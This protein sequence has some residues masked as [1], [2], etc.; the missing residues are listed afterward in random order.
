MNLT[1]WSQINYI[2]GPTDFVTMPMSPWV[3]Y[4]SRLCSLVYFHTFKQSF[5]CFPFY[6]IFLITQWTCELITNIGCVRRYHYLSSLL[7]PYTCL[8][9]HR[10]LSWI[11]KQFS[12]YLKGLASN[13]AMLKNNLNGYT[14]SS[15][16]SHFS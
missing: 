8:F 3:K 2:T 4:P 6:F 16:L 9:L 13:I 15:T 14:H 12:L 10:F 11:S 1:S 5:L 7:L